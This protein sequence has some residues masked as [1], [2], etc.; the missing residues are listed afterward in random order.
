M[1]FQVAKV[2]NRRRHYGR[3]EYLVRWT[4]TQNKEDSWEPC[5][6]LD[7]HLHLIKDY[8]DKQRTNSPVDP[9]KAS[10]AVDKGRLKKT[11][12][13]ILTGPG[14][15]KGN[16]KPD[17]D[18][19]TSKTTVTV[20]RNKSD[21]SS[22]KDTKKQTNSA[23]LKGSVSKLSTDVHKAST[24]SSQLSPRINH[25]CQTA[26]KNLQKCFDGS[27]MDTAAKLAPVVNV[28]QGK[29]IKAKKKRS[30]VDILNIDMVENTYK[31]VGDQ[32][33]R[34]SVICVKTYRD[35]VDNSKVGKNKSELASADSRG[36][37]GQGST[38]G[39]QAK[40]KPT[41]VSKSSLKCKKRPF[42]GA[43]RKY[44]KCSGNESSLKKAL[45]RARKPG[46]SDKEQLKVSN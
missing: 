5:I 44:K 6:V 40:Q 1:Q 20:T 8:L 11:V 12:D 43:K 42:K 31:L 7:N 45:I 14:Q 9:S 13:E 36:S 37:A 34:E 23:S 21:V 3:V 28:Q 17:L 4:D 46:C 26:K 33:K 19:D 35:G 38:S 27:L 22:P 41:I 25:L 15:N 24:M 29:E 32:R 16:T 30:E 18:N 2:L 39:N 10:G